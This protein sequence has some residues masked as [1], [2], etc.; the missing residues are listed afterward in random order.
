MMAKIPVNL[1]IEEDT[2][3]RFK[4]AIEPVG[5]SAS[6]VLE[7]FVRGMFSDESPTRK[8]HFFY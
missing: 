5:L 8:E 4:Q 1:T 7:V 2:I 3:N 6:G